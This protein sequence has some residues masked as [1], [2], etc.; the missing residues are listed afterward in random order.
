MPIRTAASVIVKQLVLL[1]IQSKYIFPNSF[2]SCVVNFHFVRSCNT[3]DYWVYISWFWVGRT[4]VSIL[5]WIIGETITL[6]YVEILH[7]L[8]FRVVGLTLASF[9]GFFWV[10]DSSCAAGALPGFQHGSIFKSCGLHVASSTPRSLHESWHARPV[11]SLTQNR[12]FPYI[13]SKLVPTMLPISEV[14]FCN[15]WWPPCWY[16][17][18]ISTG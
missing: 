7:S 9:L 2:I 13:L 3:M 17:I 14:M 6:I 18:P 8:Y 1:V 15:S 16:Y 5:E 12:K 11:S 4:T 10:A